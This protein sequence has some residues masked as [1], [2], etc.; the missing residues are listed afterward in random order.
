M[1]TEI[2]SYMKLFCQCGNPSGETIYFA[3]GQGD[4]CEKHYWECADCGKAVQIG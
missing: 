4:V 2:E 3:D 1:S